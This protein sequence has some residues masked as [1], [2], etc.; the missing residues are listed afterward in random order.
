MEAEAVNR[1][2]NQLNPLF[3]SILLQ[4]VGEVGGISDNSQPVFGDDFEVIT[5]GFNDRVQRKLRRIKTCTLEFLVRFGVFD[6]TIFNG[7]FFIFD[8]FGRVELQLVGVGVQLQERVF[9]KFLLHFGQ[10]EETPL[11]QLTVRSRDAGEI[12]EDALLL[13]LCVGQR[14][15]EEVKVLLFLCLGSFTT[16]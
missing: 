10:R 2:W 5:D 12:D 6:H 16:E 8:L 3:S 14:I 4:E 13:G 1:R 9:G 7:F 15:R 11:V